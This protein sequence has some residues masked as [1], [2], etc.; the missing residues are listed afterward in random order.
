MVRPHFDNWREMLLTPCRA[1]NQAQWR[2]RCV[3]EGFGRGLQKADMVL[4]FGILMH[5]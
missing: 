3:E 2:I 5:V 4:R 1:N